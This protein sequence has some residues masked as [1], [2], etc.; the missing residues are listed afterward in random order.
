MSNP[1]QSARNNSFSAV[2]DLPL[3]FNDFSDTGLT[4]AEI[5]SENI[6][7]YSMNINASVVKTELATHRSTRGKATRSA[8]EAKS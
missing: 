6:D 4:Q 3:D 1:T 5:E 8:P 7:L 2:I